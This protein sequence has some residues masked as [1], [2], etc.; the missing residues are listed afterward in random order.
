MRNHQL[1]L[2]QRVLD[3]LGEESTFARGFAQLVWALSA[4]EWEE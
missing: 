3:R 4:S 1:G 2:A